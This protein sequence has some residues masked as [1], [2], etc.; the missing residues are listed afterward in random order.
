MIALRSDE[1]IASICK[2][3]AI[4]ASALEK[5]KQAVAPGVTTGSLDALARD[6]ILKLGGYPAFNGVKVGQN[7]YP[8]NICTSVNDVVV[9]G[10]PSARRLREGDILSV[11]IGVRF[12]DYFADAA[13]TV[14]VGKVKPEAARLMKVTEEAL[15][16]AIDNA[17]VGRHLS[18]ISAAVQAHV[19]S[20]GFS[21]VRQLVG[22]GIGTKLWEEP[23]V[24]NFGRPG[25]GPVLKAGMVLAIEPMVNQGGYQVET[26]ED[27]WAIVTA[28]GKLSAHFEHTIAIRES[29]PQIL[30]ALCDKSGGF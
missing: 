13:V 25:T 7:V 10:I 14:G 4:L 6:E 8:A 11:D 15:R 2:A 17:L 29:G 3:G 22:H 1:E 5:V 23:E 19:E 18:D 26:L 27:R 16:V 9:H 20:N 21:V 12:R 30:T 28:D 24:P